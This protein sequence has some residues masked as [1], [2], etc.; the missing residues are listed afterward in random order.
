[1]VIRWNARNHKADPTLDKL[2][3]EVKH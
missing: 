3:G 2:I 1:M